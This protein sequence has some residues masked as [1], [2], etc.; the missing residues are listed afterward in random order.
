MNQNKSC[1]NYV[2]KRMTQHV[3]TFGRDKERKQG[4]TKFNTEEEQEE[5]VQYTEK[6]KGKEDKK[7]RK[8]RKKEFRKN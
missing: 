2:K 8:S 5:I 6:R 4:N 3:L 7:E 1:G